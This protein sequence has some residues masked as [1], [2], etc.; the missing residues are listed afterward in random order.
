VNV[1]TKITL[2][3][4][5]LV[6]ILFVSFKYNRTIIFDYTVENEVNTKEHKLDTHSGDL[7]ES[8][9]NFINSNTAKINTSSGNIN[10]DFTVSNLEKT[11]KISTDTS[12]NVT[13]S[14]SSSSMDTNLDN[15]STDSNTSVPESSEA[16]Y[17]EILEFEKAVRRYISK[18]YKISTLNTQNVK[19]AGFIN[20]KFLERYDVT[21]S[22]ADGGYNIIITLKYDLPEEIKAQ[23][24]NNNGISL[25][26]ETIRYTFW[27]KAYR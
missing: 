5:I 20:E 14:E 17:S 12:S 4:I 3:L 27:I 24:L 1:L 11:T 8:T 6:L 22:V 18:G 26:G 19:N 16:V 25:D 9:S 21:F 7:S 2:V 23:L 13:E 15:I 10:T